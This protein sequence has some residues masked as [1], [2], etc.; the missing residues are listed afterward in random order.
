MV[1]RQLHVTVEIDC[2]TY[3]PLYDNRDC[4]KVNVDIP[5][6]LNVERKQ[7]QYLIVPLLP[8]LMLVDLINLKE[9]NFSKKIFLILIYDLNS[10]VKLSN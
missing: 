3:H 4:N 9:F 10:D 7:T 5:P 2:Y 6:R 8:V 1:E